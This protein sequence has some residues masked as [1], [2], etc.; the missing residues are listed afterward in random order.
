MKFEEAL[1]DISRNCRNKIMDGERIKKNERHIIDSYQ[2]LKLQKEYNEKVM[3]LLYP[4]QRPSI[5]GVINDSNPKCEYEFVRFDK[6]ETKHP[7]EYI[8]ANC[9][10]YVV[11]NTDKENCKLKEDMPV[12][13]LSIKEGD[14][15]SGKMWYKHYDPKL[16]DELCE[17]LARHNWGDLKYMNKKSI[18]RDNKKLKKKGKDIGVEMGLTIKR[19]DKNNPIIVDFD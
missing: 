12:S 9:I 17:M 3:D 2:R 6:I 14:I 15:E 7:I 13:F 19:T 11:K 1:D 16:P 10:D 8:D 4:N 18:K 5:V